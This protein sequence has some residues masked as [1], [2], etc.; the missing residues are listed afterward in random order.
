MVFHKQSL[1][2]LKICECYFADIVISHKGNSGYC[3]SRCCYSSLNDDV[4]HV[5]A[6]RSLRS[7]YGFPFALIPLLVGS[8]LDFSHT[9]TTLSVGN[10]D[11]NDKFNCL[12]C[13][14]LFCNYIY[15]IKQQ[16]IKDLSRIINDFANAA[17]F[18]ISNSLG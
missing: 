10:N 9:F 6:V 12:I 4:L 2:Y 17:N 16:C 8:E 7:D 14:K 11:K 15:K 1:L 18:M 3:Q 13:K 5:A